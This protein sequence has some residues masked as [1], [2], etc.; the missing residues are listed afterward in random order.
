[1]FTW[2]FTYMSKARLTDTLNQ[3]MLNAQPGDILVR[4]HTAIHHEE[5]AVELARCIKEL[6]PKARIIGTSTTA[7]IN[8]GKLDPN[9]CVISVTQMDSC[10]VR[11]ALLPTHSGINRKKVLSPDGLCQRVK[12]AV[13][14]KDTKLMLVFMTASYDGVNSFVEKSNEFFPGVQMIGGIAGKAE[15]NL[16]ESEEGFVFNETGW[17]KR[18]VLVASVSGPSLKCMTDCVTGMQVIGQEMKIT[19]AKGNCILTIDGVDASQKI[20]WDPKGERE[21]RFDVIN[22][23]P[24]ASVKRG[25]VP[26]KVQYVDGQLYA[27]HELAEGEKIKRA[28]IYDRRIVADNR[29]MFQRIENFENAEIIF[30]YSGADRM[31]GYSNCVKW[32][33]S[34]YE[35]SNA[36]GCVLDGEI[37]NAEGTNIFAKCLFAVAAFGEKKDSQQYNPYIFSCADV[38]SEDN[39][40]ILNY[41][42]ELEEENEANGNPSSEEL[43]TFLD[44]CEEK[45]FYSEEKNLPN[46]A[47]LKYDID[48]KGYDRVCVINVLDI[49]SMKLV[50][51][52]KMIQRTYK[53]YVRKCMRVAKENKYH[54]YVLEDW[55]FAISAP[56]YVV[57]LDDFVKNMEILYRELFE[58]SKEYVAF[59]PNVCI[60][61][62]CTT[63]NISASYNS[64]R[65]DMMRKNVQFFVCDADTG[66]LDE[67]SIQRKYHMVN[68]I[69]YALSHDT[70]IPY[71]QGIYDNRK[72]TICHY[73][74]LMRLVDENGTVYLPADFL[75]VARSYGL[76][77]DSLSFTMIKKVFHRFEGMEGKA[78]SINLGIRDVKN[79]EIVE[80]IYDFLSTTK[81]PENFIFELLENED[82]GDYGLLL[83]F[84]DKIHELGGRISIDDFGSG[85]SNL[86]HVLSIQSDY[87]KIDGSIIKNCCVDKDAENLIALISVWKNLS[88]RKIKIVAEYVENEDIQKKLT[89]Y[90]VDYSQGYLFSKPSP[91]LINEH[92]KRK[93]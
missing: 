5:E 23:F 33:V 54:F 76:I 65:L 72:R 58:T 75:E 16:D 26:I 69:N 14:E 90:D 19:K 49:A 2:N 18:G 81:H 71:Y 56:S 29:S 87:V 40:K 68:I 52:E 77:Y 88:N 47:A 85:Y 61:Y 92:G 11:S 24:F 30:C 84:V 34:A 27:D 4:I 57:S 50:F 45:L 44:D 48:L 67:E 36:C 10:N 86:Q 51:S 42:Y 91:N 38:F 43:R 83:N 22:L 9:Q 41:L 32:E 6:V 79:R 17:S 93:K 12:E 62:N 15:L 78:V 13:V 31:H 70:L 20:F 39:Q 82:V 1:M 7:V 8:G 89:K 73:E 55:K 66:E 64:A 53:N 59:V 25:N 60:L 35:N 37:V 3:L 80:Y 46:E 63:E 28:M 74:A 21:E